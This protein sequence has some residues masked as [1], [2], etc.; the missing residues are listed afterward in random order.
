MKLAS[1]NPSRSNPFGLRPLM[2]AL[3][4]SAALLLAS[5]A[6]AADFT[7]DSAAAGVWATEAPWNPSTGGPPVAGDTAIF[8]AVGTD[9]RFR[10]DA[11]VGNISKIGTLSE[12]IQN[13]QAGDR[14]LTVNGLLSHTSGSGTMIFQS[15]NVSGGRLMGLNLNNVTVDGAGTL[16]LGRNVNANDQGL[17]S[18]SASG[19]TSIQN[20]G[21]L[22]VY[23]NPAVTADFGVVDF[24]ATGNNR[25]YFNDSTTA[26]TQNNKV[27]TVEGLTGGSMSTR[28]AIQESNLTA[29]ANTTL[30]LDGSGTYSYAGRIFNNGGGGAAS[31]TSVEVTGGGV[32][33]LTQ[34]SDWGGDTAIN[35]G[36]LLVD[37]SHIGRGGDYTIGANGW[38]GGA[39]TLGTAA[40]ISGDTMSMTFAAGAGL[41]FDP[42]ETLTVDE[43]DASN[44]WTLDFTN[45]SVTDLVGRD[46]SAIV[47]S[48]ITDGIYTLIDGNATFTNIDTG[49][50]NDI[51]GS[52]KN[53]RFQEGSLQLEV[54]PE[55]STYAA[56]LG[57]LAFGLVMARR[58]RS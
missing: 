46:G 30:R 32:Q 14:T 9:V 15:N 48:S 21:I 25:F 43:G 23:T 39:G 1:P 3:A 11:T 40:G 50:V 4:G 54:V 45:L 51:G 38:I 6:S 18:L 41:V 5:Q 58:R 29:G 16:R 7:W 12:Q 56:L 55:P 28:V 2:S 13:D 10:A 37:G 20:G 53:V 26:T 35:N 22:S 42:L 19:T 34:Q 33:I 31:L 57:L 44:T 27:V 49:W 17:S 52:G 8:N 47:W 24:S 36:A